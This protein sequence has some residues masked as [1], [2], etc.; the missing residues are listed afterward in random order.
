MRLRA[1]YELG[2]GESASTSLVLDRELK[3]YSTLTC[4]RRHAFGSILAVTDGRCRAASSSRI[5][6]VANAYVI[7]AA[8]HV[9]R[10]AT[11][12]SVGCLRRPRPRHRRQGKGQQRSRYDLGLSALQS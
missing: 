2:I 1:G 8:T 12:Q 4:G 9:V 5:A 10:L 3:R 11:H 6:R 7:A